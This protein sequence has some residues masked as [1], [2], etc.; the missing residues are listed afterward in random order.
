MKQR[1]PNGQ[2]TY[3]LQQ[4]LLPVKLFFLSGA[5]VFGVTIPLNSFDLVNVKAS[6]TG[7]AEAKVLPT[8]SSLIVVSPSPVPHVLTEKEQIINYI[9]EVFG[10]DAP[11]AFNVLHCENRNLDP[12]A[13]NHNRN[14]SQDLGIFQ[15]NN[16][17]WGG[18]ENL[19]WKTNIDKAKIVFDRAGKSWKPWTCS[20]RIGVKSYWQN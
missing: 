15:L 5:F 2:F 12:K 7:L 9:V 19:N 8:Q 3:D 17:Y 16:R 10:E 4:K 18:E 20:T 11:E 6:E 1:K 13:I 14:G